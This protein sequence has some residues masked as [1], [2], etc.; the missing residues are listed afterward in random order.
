MRHVIAIAAVIALSACSKPATSPEDEAGASPAASTPPT[1]AN[2]AADG[3]PAPGMYKITTGDGK[4]RMEEVKADGTYE[5]R[6]DGKV[7]E[8]GKWEQKSPAL[9]C[10]TID[11]PNPKQACN[12]EKIENG[13]WTS[14]GPE[15]RTATVER[16]G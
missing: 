5:T 15:G 2:I 1:A 6:A 7:I 9:Y 10:Y 14:K 4:V 13:V 16:V 3:K 12:E 11:G 8:T